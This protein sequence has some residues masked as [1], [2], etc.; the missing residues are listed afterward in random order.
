MIAKIKNYL[1]TH[2]DIFQ[3]VKFT[4][5]SMLAFLVEYAS[6]TILI[7]CLKNVN[8]PLNWFV[9]SYAADD[10]GSGAFIAFLISTVLAQIVTF[11]INRKKT[12]NANNN[13]VFSAIAYAV[14][15][16]GIVVLNTWMGGAITSALSSA[17]W[18]VTLSQY[19]GKLAGSFASFVIIFL[20]SKFVIMRRVD[21][22][23]GGTAQSAQVQ[24]EKSE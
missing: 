10:G 14:M 1:N 15:V 3:L 17:N 21:K 6:F 19:V 9:F 8:Q 4:I 2:K 18:N 7:L 16:C 24:E 12:F 22:K 11:V 20:M 13:I 5:F 23:D